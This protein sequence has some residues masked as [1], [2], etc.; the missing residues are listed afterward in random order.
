MTLEDTSNFSSIPA[1]SH[2]GSAV[3]PAS[4]YNITIIPEVNYN[5]QVSIRYDIQPQVY[6]VKSPIGGLL[7]PLVV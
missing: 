5:C 3:L 6:V 1:P 2:F 4:E 7:H